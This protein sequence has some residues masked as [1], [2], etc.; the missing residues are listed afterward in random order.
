[1]TKPMID[2]S[3]DVLL[4]VD[5]SRP[6][7]VYR[8]LH[9]SC[10]SVRQDGIVRCHASGSVCLYDAKFVV[11]QGGREKVLREKKKNVHAFIKGYARSARDTYSLLDFEWNG[12]Y[13]NPYSCEYFKDIDADRYV[14]SAQWVEIAGQPCDLVSQI[15]AFN[16]KWR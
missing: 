1:M 15:L 4:H 10:L 14:D 8:N 12:V 7:E 6:V 3:A 5:P 13:Y 11:R 2:R 9:K 16:I